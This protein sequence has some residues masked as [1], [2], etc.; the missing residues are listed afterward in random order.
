MEYSNSNSKKM[1]KTSRSSGKP[2]RIDFNKVSP[3]VE[4]HPYD[5]TTFAKAKQVPMPKKLTWFP[6]HTE[7]S[8]QFNDFNT[9]WHKKRYQYTLKGS[10]LPIERQGAQ[11]QGYYKHDKE[12]KKKLDGK[13][14]FRKPVGD[15]DLEQYDLELESQRD[16]QGAEIRGYVQLNKK[17][18]VQAVK[19]MVK[20]VN[21]GRANHSGYFAHGMRW[22][23]FVAHQAKADGEFKKEHDMADEFA[24]LSIE[25]NKQIEDAEMG[26]NVASDEFGKF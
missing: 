11:G 25:K 26:A 7:F 4:R 2:K 9:E 6:K 14:K 18:G 20:K 12:P 21:R 5:P 17:K 19:Q 16:Q 15:L 3:K 24:G 13:F 8:L 23:W 22:K 1:T 10:M